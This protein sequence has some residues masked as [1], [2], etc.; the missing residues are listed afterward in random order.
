MRYLLDGSQARAVDSYNIKELG[1]PSLALMERAALAV[2]QEA[3]RRTEPGSRVLAVCGMGNNGADGL[4]AARMLKQRGRDV[5]VVLCGNPENATE[6]HE[7]QLAIVKKLGISV[8]TADNEAEYPIKEGCFSLIIDALFGVGLKRPLAGS[9]A[10]AV[11][12]MNESG[13]PILAVD[14]PSGISAASGQVLGGAVRASATVT[15]GYE[16][17]GMVLYPGQD[18]C[19]HTTVADIGF[20]APGWLPEST[21]RTSGPE[22]LQKLPVR[23]ADGN[24]G[25][26]GKVLVF[27]GSCGMCGAAYLSALAAYRTGAGL[28]R[29]FTV[30]ENVPVLQTML[31]EAIVT[32][33]DR[34]APDGSQAEELVRWADVLV[35]GP[36]LSRAPYART[37]LSAFLSNIRIPAVLDADALNLL[38]EDESLRGL[39]KDG[40][41]LTP[42]VGE[43]ARLTGKTVQEIK[44]AP[45]ETAAGVR[46]RY[47]VVCVLKDARTIVASENG[48]YVNTSGNCAMA[49]G[50]SGDV[51]SGVIGGL[52]AGGMDP[53]G[54][55]EAGV[56]LHGAAGDA[57]AAKL[58]K[59]AVL[60]SDIIA[61][62]PD[63][64][65]VYAP[66]GD[67][68]RAGGGRL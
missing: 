39:L 64:L 17:L 46:D 50:G 36:G 53:A 20:S 63:I 14:I 65:K 8:R 33:Y 68:Y 35:A 34:T 3:E 4:A 15:F 60:A 62:I 56:Y 55:A 41:I 16:K 30:Q 38:S 5:E 6:E 10:T 11:K 31:P 22:I 51:L 18:Y 47:G 49:T 13:V 61:G 12:A 21:A 37:L 9:F 42:H 24:K 1:I 28:V 58:G 54:A 26:F 67:S 52:L 23:P 27:A 57:A 44:A 43:M 48:I 32:G 29:I 40:M 25:T 59:H 45:A 7:I 66:S 19:G 2:F